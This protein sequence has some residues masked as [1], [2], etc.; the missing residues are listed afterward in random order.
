MVEGSDRPNKKARRVQRGEGADDQDDAAAFE[1]SEVVEDL[2]TL[3]G[4]WSVEVLGEDD[5]QLY[6]LEV[7]TA[8]WADC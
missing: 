5:S 4:G 1:G 8:S 3:D 6:D 7:R 2:F